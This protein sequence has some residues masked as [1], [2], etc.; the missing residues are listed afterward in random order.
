MAILLHWFFS[1]CG[2]GDHF[3]HGC[4][5]SALRPTSTCEG[6]CHNFNCSTKC[7]QD[8]GPFSHCCKISPYFDNV[9]PFS[10][11]SASFLL[12]QLSDALVKNYLNISS[13]IHILDDLFFPYQHPPPSVQQLCAKSLPCLRTWTSWLPLKKPFGLHGQCCWGGHLNRFA[14]CGSSSLLL[15]GTLQFACR[16]ISLGQAFLQRIINFSERTFTCGTFSRSASFF[17]LFL[18][19]YIETSPDIHLYT[20]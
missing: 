9:L 17:S 16:V 13:I 5:L 11:R 14:T 1:V 2:S 8:P 12:N 19:P 18:P 7:S 10:L 20:N 4:S 15:I 3:S 6:V